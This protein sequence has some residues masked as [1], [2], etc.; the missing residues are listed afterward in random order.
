M[1]KLV[2]IKPKRIL[3]TTI[4]P[5][6]ERG[7]VSNKKPLLRRKNIIHKKQKGG[8]GPPPAVT[9]A[10][11]DFYKT[12]HGLH[13]PGGGGG[14]HGQAP[15]II[16]THEEGMVTVT[17]DQAQRIFDYIQN[18]R[19]GL[20]PEEAAQ[21]DVEGQEQAAPP[22]PPVPPPPIMQ[23]PPT[24]M[25]HH[26]VE[27]E[28]DMFYDAEGQPQ[29]TGSGLMVPREDDDDDGGGV[30]LVTNEKIHIPQGDCYKVFAHP[31]QLLIAGATQ[32]GKTTLI[33]EILK[34]V[35]L[36][37]TEVPSE[38]YWF[39]GHD[40]AIGSVKSVLP[41]MK[42]RNGA[43]TQKFL[44]DLGGDKKPKMIIMDDLQDSL[45][46]K[47]SFNTIMTILN[48]VSHHQG[49]SFVF[50]AQDLFHTNMI[51]LRGQCNET[52]IM[53]DGSPTMKNAKTLA[54]EMGMP[55]SFLVDCVKKVKQGTS[56]G[57]LL[58]SR[59]A[60]AGITNV[61]SGITPGHPLQTF[62]F[63]KGT[64]TNR[65]YIWLKKHGK[66]KEEAEGGEWRRR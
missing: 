16:P 35:H 61:R 6:N 39:H 56:Y 45:D 2:R 27:D 4:P 5:P 49:I 59:G 41:G 51:R 20:S 11:P 32:S 36:M 57:H 62:Y 47:E 24:P 21:K 7:K 8:N 60:N 14:G 37:F 63:A 17:K 44:L 58:V 15:P 25:Q 34:N 55:H 1:P 53:T 65:D 13:A 33:T 28:E 64:E 54:T 29:M 42:F 18:R 31:C 12:P 50:L 46:R 23:P 43:P 22:P 10:A 3:H 19:K 9:E 26:G 48:Q 30:E 66:E 52:I 38:V 40:E